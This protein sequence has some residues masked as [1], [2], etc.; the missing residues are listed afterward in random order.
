M[1]FGLAYEK[2]CFF[3]WDLFPLCALFWFGLSYSLEISIPE[4]ASE[5]VS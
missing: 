2:K 3:F 5:K 4:E 1:T